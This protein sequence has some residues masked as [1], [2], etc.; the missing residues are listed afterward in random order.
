MGMVK[1]IILNRWRRG[2]VFR[3]NFG[4]Q[5]KG[6]FT[7]MNGEWMQ[8]TEEVHNL[9]CVAARGESLVQ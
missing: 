3:Y 6:D 4:Y 9:A 8:R 7:I 2:E 1:S 5:G